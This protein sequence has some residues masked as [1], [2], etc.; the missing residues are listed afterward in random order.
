[1]V[2]MAMVKTIP[3]D[4]AICNHLESG[5]TDPVNILKERTMH[6]L[7]LFLHLYS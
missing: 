5:L 4:D 1:M 6:F 7:P 3:E 2:G